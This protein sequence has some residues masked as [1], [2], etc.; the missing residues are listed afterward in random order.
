[1]KKCIPAG[2][3]ALFFCL[4]LVTNL[5][6]AQDHGQHGHAVDSELEFLVEMIPH[7]Q[8]AVDSASIILKASKRKELRSFAR[9]IMKVQARE[10]AMMKQW[11]DQW[12]PESEKQ[13]AYKPMMRQ[14]KGLPKDRAEIVFIEDMIEH[15]LAAVE[16]AREV[17]DKGLARHDEVADLARQIVKTQTQEINLMQQWLEAW[18]KDAPPEPAKRH[19]H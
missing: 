15:H 5:N 2:F 1:M 9:E 6:A 14:L 4:A 18:R 7:H 17:L 12:Y 13:S 11:L 8:E 19:G 3:F 10:I 16:M